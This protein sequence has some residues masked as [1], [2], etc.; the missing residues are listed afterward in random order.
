[1]TLHRCKTCGGDLKAVQDGVFKCVCCGNTQSL[2]TKSSVN[3]QQKQINTNLSAIAIE[4]VYNSAIEAMANQKYDDAIR[5]FS[6]VR[7]YLDADEKSEHCQRMLTESNNAEIYK[8]ACIT[9][10]SAKNAEN[11]KAAAYIFNQILDYK[12]SA[13]LMSK[14]L[15]NAETL[16]NEE[17]YTQAC[18]MMNEYNIHF[19]QKA[20]N[21]FASIPT[22]KDSEAKQKECLA[23]IENQ[24]V[25]IFKKNVDLQRAKNKAARKKKIITFTVIMAIVLLIVT[26]VSVRKANHS[27]SDIDIAI[28]DSRTS[29]NYSYYYFHSDYKITNNTA[30]TID[31]IKVV[32]YVSDKSG[33]SLGTITSTFGSEYGSDVLNLKA[34]ES[35]IQETYLSEYS[36]KY[37]DN[38]FVTLYNNGIKNFVVTHEIVNVTWSDGYTYSK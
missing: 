18:E 30:K 37:M 16:K 17:L 36:S 20:A 12:D 24:K 1:M 19:L 22:F 3:A 6:N 14:C 38:F 32:T 13:V 27:V 2:N 28:V 35:T 23:L 31:Y 9:L 25:E 15:S 8:N 26:I 10:A 11:Y 34:H 29:Q 33:K 5:L 4:N 21:I 7:G